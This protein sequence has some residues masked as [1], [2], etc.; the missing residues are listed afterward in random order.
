MNKPPC[1]NC[2]IRALGC[3]SL[4][5]KYIDWRKEFRAEMRDVEKKNKD[6][7]VYKGQF[8]GTSPPPG[9]HRKTRGTR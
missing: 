2:E 6:H 9:K 1:Y 7:S 5:N 3:H 8:L 4:C